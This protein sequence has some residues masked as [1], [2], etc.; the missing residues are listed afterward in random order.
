MKG[1]DRFLL[2]IVIGLVLLVVV[3]FVVVLARPEPDYQAEDTPEGVVFNYLLA[4]QNQDYER[5]YKYLSPSMESYPESARQFT[6]DVENNR[7]AFRLNTDVSL[8]VEDFTEIGDHAT[9]QVRES[10]FYGGDIFDSGHSSTTFTMHLL[11][12]SGEWKIA[13]S[14]S[15]F[16]W[17]WKN[18]NGCR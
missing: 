15:Y 8:S 18:K 11:L 1:V 12:E 13:D 10:R 16:A 9:V 6:R 5:A 3:T 4:L 7:W 14:Q 2:A 17:C